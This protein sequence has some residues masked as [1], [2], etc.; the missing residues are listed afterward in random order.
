MVYGSGNVGKRNESGLETDLVFSY[1]VM[2]SFLSM[3]VGLKESHPFA[4]V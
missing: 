1:K 3:K 4:P 2:L